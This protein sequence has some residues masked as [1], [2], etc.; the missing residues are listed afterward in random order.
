MET[1]RRYPSD[2]SPSE[3]ARVARLVPPPKSGGRPAKYDR[4]EV[5]NALLYVARTGCQWRGLP[6]DLPPWTI[7]YWYFRC[8]EADGTLDRL[9]AELRRGLPSAT[10]RNRRLAAQA[11]EA[12]RAATASAA[13]P[14]A[15]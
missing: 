10:R 12:H 4:K 8:W 1:R 6:D 2:L 5:L 3:W 9:R 15:A 13:S 11:A 14:P 7:A